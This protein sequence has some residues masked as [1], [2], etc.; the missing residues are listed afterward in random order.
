LTEKVSARLKAASLAGS[1]VTLK[2]KSADFKLRTRARALGAPTQL[3][4]RIF[5]AGRDL[6]R[7]EVGST[8]FRLIGIGVSSLSD[9]EGSDLSDLIDRRAAG[10]E[11][12]VDKLRE[13]F[14]RDAVV[15]G[16]A[17]EDE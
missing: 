8:R 3:A 2:L 13:K 12:A 15:K 9:A 4:A 17:L 11:L 7:H 5:A 14:G 1:T 16:L 10:A 6:L